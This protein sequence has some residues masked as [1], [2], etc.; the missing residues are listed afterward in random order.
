MSDTLQEFYDS[1]NSRLPTNPIPLEIGECKDNKSL[2]IFKKKKD[3][4]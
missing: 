2:K 1:H 4:K 3:G